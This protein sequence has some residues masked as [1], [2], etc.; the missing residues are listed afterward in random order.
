MR[1]G[2]ELDRLI[3]VHVFGWSEHRIDPPRQDEL[4]ATLVSIL[5]APSGQVSVMPCYSTSIA[6][7]WQIV[8]AL[9]LRGLRLELVYEADAS[10][11]CSV[12]V[13]GDKMVADGMSREEAMPLAICKAALEALGVKV[14]SCP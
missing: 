10:R 5:I 11:A 4:G 8:E 1:A 2:R 6:D 13:W 14:P 9:H 12:I 3:A 7:A